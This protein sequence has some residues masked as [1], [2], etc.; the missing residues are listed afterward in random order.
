MPAQRVGAKRLVDAAGEYCAAFEPR[1]W[2]TAV[3]NDFDFDPIHGLG[4][5]AIEE[6]VAFFVGIV[7]LRRREDWARKGNHDKFG[8]ERQTKAVVFAGTGEFAELA[9]EI[10]AAKVNVPAIG[11][12]PVKRNQELRLNLRQTLK[13]RANFER[14]ENFLPFGQTSV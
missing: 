6:F 10:E 2:L 5:G 8:S 13:K 9:D 4:K 7:A 3:V 11:K 14:F 12:G 1:F